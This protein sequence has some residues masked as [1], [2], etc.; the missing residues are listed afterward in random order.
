MPPVQR[1]L[2]LQHRTGGITFSMMLTIE[3]M[4]AHINYVGC[5]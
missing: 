2:R 1:I 4:I 5:G 3:A